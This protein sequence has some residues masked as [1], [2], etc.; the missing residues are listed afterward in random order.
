MATPGR[1]PD[2]IERVE[3]IVGVAL[4]AVFIDIHRPAKPVAELDRAVAEH[5]VAQRRV[6]VQLVG[7]E[8]AKHPVLLQN[9]EDHSARWLTA[10]VTPVRRGNG[11]VQTAALR[12]SPAVFWRPGQSPCAPRAVPPITISPSTIALATAWVVL[13]AESLKRAL[14]I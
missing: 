11:R 9:R 10:S 14:S 7:I 1:L 8:I 12:R 3:R 13:S 4:H 6:G 5:R 2:D